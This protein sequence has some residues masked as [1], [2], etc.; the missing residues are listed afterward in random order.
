MIKPHSPHAAKKLKAHVKYDMR[1][2]LAVR[3]LL[4]LRAFTCAYVRFNTFTLTLVVRRRV[5]RIAKNF[6]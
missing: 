6:F 3:T 2:F 4:H 5:F 1:F